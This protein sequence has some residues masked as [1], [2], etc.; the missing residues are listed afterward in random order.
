MSCSIPNPHL[1]GSKCHRHDQQLPLLR[2][3][4]HD[5]HQ[6]HCSVQQR[7]H[8][9]LLSNADFMQHSASSPMLQGPANY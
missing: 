5:V 2:G 9:L 1:E 3:A 8:V 6:L 7:L 4:R